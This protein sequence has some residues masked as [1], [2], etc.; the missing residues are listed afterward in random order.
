MVKSYYTLSKNHFVGAI[1]VLP[2]TAASKINDDLWKSQ[3]HRHRLER[4]PVTTFYG[5]ED[6]RIWHQG[7]PI[8]VFFSSAIE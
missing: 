4:T 3:G 6:G 1:Y 2:F 8:A 5:Y 7:E